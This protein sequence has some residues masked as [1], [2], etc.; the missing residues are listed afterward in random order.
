MATHLDI[1]TYKEIFKKA[2]TEWEKSLDFNQKKSL[3]DLNDAKFQSLLE[4]IEK[5][6]REY[7]NSW[8]LKPGGDYYEFIVAYE[9]AQKSLAAIQ[10]LSTETKNKLWILQW[11]VPVPQ[12]GWVTQVNGLNWVDVTKSSTE[13]LLSPEKLQ[14]FWKA[15]QESIKNP[16]TIDTI[17]TYSELLEKQ[18][19]PKVRTMA[20]NLMWSKLGEKWYVMTVQNGKIV[21]ENPTDKSTQEQAVVLTSTLNSNLKAN[22]FFLAEIQ[23]AIMTGTG[24]FGEYVRTQEAN[25]NSA[26]LE[27]YV[28]QLTKILG[29]TFIPKNVKNI[30]LNNKVIEKNLTMIQDHKT[31]TPQEKAFLRSYINGGYVG[32]NVVP[33]IQLKKELQQN[34][35]VL[36]NS[37]SFT[38][39]EMAVE[40]VAG[41]KVIAQEKAD[42]KQAW[43]EELTIESFMDNPASAITK[44]P[45]T[46]L[47]L[48]IGSIYQFGFMKTFGGLFAGM[49]GIKA[50]NE[51]GDTKLG[52]DLKKWVEKSANEAVD[53]A[54]NAATGATLAPAVV[55]PAVTVS[56]GVD[57]TKLTDFQKKAY[58]TI[59][60]DKVFLWSI[61]TFADKKIQAKQVEIAKSGKYMEFIFS[62]NFQKIPL[63]KFIYTNNP[64]I[65]IFRSTETLDPSLKVPN[66][67]N[68]SLLKKMILLYL[69]WSTTRELVSGKQTWDKE[70]EEFEKNYP[71]ATWKTKT[72]SDITKKIY[73]NK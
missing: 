48:I 55:A 7:P 26:S 42:L 35:I 22:R 64:D 30:T 25:I 3:A 6:K 69:T 40:K 51:L 4:V 36:K 72:L 5:E 59:N 67:L 62:E 9:S 13:A 15:F 24:W 34:N 66:E 57:V 10:L 44:Y 73:Q 60:A 46:S 11:Q 12:A 50:V 14:A 32:Y 38:Q 61:D 2:S 18:T 27:E 1:Q 21:L 23:A 70:K 54:T 20:I 39:T 45:W 16:V 8:L 19:D 68:N 43:K 63:E 41:P 28:E 56:G 29:I 65:S 47:A 49:I 37:E 58:D 31:A 71:V 33:A 53:A 17:N 52:K